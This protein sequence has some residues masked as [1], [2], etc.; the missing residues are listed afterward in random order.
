MKNNKRRKNPKF[1][2]M[3]AVSMIFMVFTL[4]IAIT[5]FSRSYGFYSSDKFVYSFLM[6][7]FAVLLGYFLAKYLHQMNKRR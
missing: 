7:Y 2:F 3:I 4:I 1:D 5:S 6:L